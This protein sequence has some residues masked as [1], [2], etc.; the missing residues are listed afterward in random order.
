MAFTWELPLMCE[1]IQ[2]DVAELVNKL[3]HITKIRGY[4][5]IANVIPAF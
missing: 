2:C 5:K 4:K 3:C 1:D